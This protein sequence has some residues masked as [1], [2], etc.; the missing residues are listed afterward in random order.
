MAPT[1]GG[2]APQARGRPDGLGSTQARLAKRA[3]EGLARANEIADLEAALARVHHLAGTL[4]ATSPELAPAAQMIR[5]AIGPGI[6]A[7]PVPLAG[8]YE[9]A[10]WL[11]AHT[12]TPIAPYVVQQALV[13]N[14]MGP[15]TPP[16]T[17]KVVN[18]GGREVPAWDITPAGRRLWTEW[19]DRRP[20]RGNGLR[21]P[22]RK[23]PEAEVEA[24]A[25]GTG[26]AG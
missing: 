23:K 18:A 17:H 13:R 1:K 11:S 26:Q 25:G 19:W 12:G 14:P 21:G 15:P 10:L 6:P 5:D 7:G 2:A 24:E 3:A 9:V 4:Q 16:P 22:T 8:Q 20:G